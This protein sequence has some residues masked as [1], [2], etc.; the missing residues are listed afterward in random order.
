MK[1]VKDR[2]GIG[3]L[4]HAHGHSNVYCRIMQDFARIVSAVTRR[5]SL[6]F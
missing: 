2:V 3:V 6:G 1:E 5:I 4:S